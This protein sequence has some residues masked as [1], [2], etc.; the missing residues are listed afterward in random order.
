M[1][2]TVRSLSVSLWLQPGGPNTPLE[3]LGCHAITGVTEPLGN[4]TLNYCP[5]PVQ[6]GKY[7]ISSKTKAPPGLVTYSIESKMYKLFDHLENVKCPAPVIAQVVDCSPKNEFWNW[8]RAFVFRNSDPVQ[9]GISNLLTMSEESETTMTFDMEADELVR[10]AKLRVARDS[11]IGETVALNSIFACDIDR[12]AGACGAANEQCNT[13]YAVSDAIVGSASG[14]ADVWINENGTWSVAAADPF[15]TGE[16]IMAG[17]CFAI[18]GSTRRLLVFRGSTDAGNPAE[19]AYSDDGGATWTTVNIGSDNGEFVASPHAVFALNQ[20]NIWVGTD[21]GR[22]YFSNDAGTTWSVQE[23]AGIHAAAWNWIY[24][25]D[26]RNGVAGG[27]GDVIATTTDGGDVWSQV[28]ATGQGGDITAGAV[29]D[30]NNFWVGTDDGELFYTTDAGVTW[31]QRVGFAGSGVGR[32]DSM[33]FLNEQIGYVSMRNGSDKSTLLSTR[34]GGY[35]WEVIET[36]TN[37]GINA[38]I[39]CGLKLLYAVGEASGG[40]PVVYKAQPVS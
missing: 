40:K 7:K 18:D 22:I 36:P 11:S 38:M 34:T 6:P 32:V 5:D 37:S 31:N 12:C 28:N 17:V 8:Q 30:V 39:A 21:S 29:I 3:F 14:K 23:D 24:M 27:A 33:V 20:N 1:A 25:L 35:N 26:D 13:F 16:H 2:D 15:G 4:N 19:A 10:I 9:R